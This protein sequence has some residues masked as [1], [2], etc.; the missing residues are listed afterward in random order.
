MNSW[1]DGSDLIELA[2]GSTQAAAGRAPAVAPVIPRNPAPRRISIFGLGYVGAVSAACFSRV[3]HTVIGLDVN[4]IKRQCFREGKPPVVEA[5]LDDFMQHGVRSGRLTATDDI[6]Q[7]IRDTDVSLI[8]VGTPSREN[9]SINT[10]TVGTV[11][12]E[13]GRALRDKQGEHLVVIR[14]TMIP[15]TMRN[16]KL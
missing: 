5:G 9:G 10:D 1:L 16:T 6:N 7:A 3:G 14:S 13:I 12:A 4:D 2:P 11:V 15:G 8:C